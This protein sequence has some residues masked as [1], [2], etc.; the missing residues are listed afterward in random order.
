MNR[1]VYVSNALYTVLRVQF[2][3]PSI[4]ASVGY[5]HKVSW[6]AWVSLAYIR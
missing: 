6:I 5:M 3:L 1:C 4:T 2:V